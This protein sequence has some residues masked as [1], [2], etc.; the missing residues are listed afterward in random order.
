MLNIYLLLADFLDLTLEDVGACIEIIYTP[1][2]KDGIKGIPKH[3]VSDLIS[4]GK[5]VLLV[6]LDML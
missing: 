5:I 6:K 1:V 3:I 4:P 2:R